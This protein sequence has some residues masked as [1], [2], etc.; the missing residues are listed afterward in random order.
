[1]P[2]MIMY[3]RTYSGFSNK[4]L[5][6]QHA[7]ELSKSL[8]ADGIDF[9]ETKIYTAGYDPPYKTKDRRNEVMFLGRA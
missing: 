4:L 9:D 2:E 1:M 8:K 3:V 7:K 5:M 6:Q